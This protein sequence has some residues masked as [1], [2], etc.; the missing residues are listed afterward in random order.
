MKKTAF[1]I[2]AA[3]TLAACGGPDKPEKL[4]TEQEMENIMYDISMLQAIRSFAPQKLTDNNVNA[5]TY[6]FKKYKIDSLT[7]AQNQLYYAQN[8]DAYKKI[9]KSV[10]GRLNADKEKITGKKAK[11]PTGPGAAPQTVTP[12]ATEASQVPQEALER[13]N[14][15]SKPKVLTEQEKA[16]VKRRRD[17]IR[18][19]AQKKLQKA[20]VNKVNR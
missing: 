17:S 4:L 18:A 19:V 13:A 10:T 1:I 7:L 6:I 8:L 11:T 3:I 15:V 20:P 2:I 16:A 14:A 9:Q 12:E 5:H